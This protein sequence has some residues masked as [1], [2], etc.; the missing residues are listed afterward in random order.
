M[1]VLLTCITIS[2]CSPATGKRKIY[3]F[4]HELGH[5][6]LK[7]RITQLAFTACTNIFITVVS[8]Q[9]TLK[10]IIKN[11]FSNIS[12][13]SMAKCKE[14]KSLPTLYRN[15]EKVAGES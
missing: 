11:L 10:N 12:P 15:P 3:H 9:N 13:S 14:R 8:F 1:R 6:S 7:S 5:F 2:C 4:H